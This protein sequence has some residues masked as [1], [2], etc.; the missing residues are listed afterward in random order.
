[1]INVLHVINGADLGGISSMILNYYRNINRD[2]FHF[3]FIYSIDEPLGHNGI[4]LQ[5]LGAQFFYVPKKSEGLM[6][7]IKGIE[8]ILKARKYDAIHVHSSLTS[9]VALAV[10]K[11]CGIRVRVAHAHNAVKDV[12]GVK[13]KINRVIGNVLIKRYATVRL[14]C[15]R[16]AA[17]YTFG[18]KSINDN[19]V[20][21]LP[22]SIATRNYV[23]SE[24]KRK[25][26]RS[27]YNIGENEL[28]FGT[29]GRM[30]QEK[31]ILYLIDVLDSLVK[32][33]SCRL[34][35]IG[36]GD[37]RKDIEEKIEQLGIR[38][39]AILTGK[40]PDVAALLNAFDVFTIPSV[41]EG[42][43]IAG[44]EAGANGLPLVMS[45]AVPNDLG[46]LPNTIYLSLGNPQKWAET[47]S[48][49]H[50]GRNENAYSDVRSHGYD[51]EDSVVILEAVYS[52]QM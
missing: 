10:A 28:V 3:D 17:I 7:H 24:E 36:D 41:N 46:F 14:A 33:R 45:N 30:S 26:V 16:D 31:N 35:L 50:K 25:E 21:V 39:H 4:E 12:L 2:K 42:F 29:V 15:S 8:K 9:Y 38:N 44:L 32:I 52:G 47:I 43:S 13:A 1:M 19:N 27:V 23:F 6:A 48:S 49:Y 22:N 11:K 5:K 34:M 51:I 18:N 40:R 20:K 37:E